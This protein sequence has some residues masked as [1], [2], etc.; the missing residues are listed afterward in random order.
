MYKT[1]PKDNQNAH[2]HFFVFSTLAMNY[3]K[4]FKSDLQNLA[5]VKIEI[6]LNF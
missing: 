6:K 5:S 2:L 4:W 1:W 3:I